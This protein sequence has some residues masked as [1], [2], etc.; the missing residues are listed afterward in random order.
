MNLFTHMAEWLNRR[1]IYVF[2][3]LVIFFGWYYFVG[4]FMASDAIP[5]GVEYPR[6]MHSF[7]V[8]E[9][10]ARCGTCMLWS[11]NMG[12]YPAF[13]DIYGAF[14]HPVAVIMSLLFGAIQGSKLTVIL[15]FLMIAL[16]TWWLSLILSMH[17]IARIWAAM[18]SMFGGHIAARLEVGSVGLPLSIAAG[19][20]AIVSVYYFIENPSR[21]RAILT[22][23]MLGMFILAGQGYYQLGFVLSVPLF[24]LLAYRMDMFEKPRQELTRYLTQMTVV[25]VGIAAPLLYTFV[26]YGSY[27]DK[28]RDDT[29]SASMSIFKLMENWFNTN[30]DIVY[31]TDFNALPFPYLYSTYIGYA[32]VILAVLGIIYI[33]EKHLRLLYDFFSLFALVQF[34]TA[35]GDF[36]KW[37]MSFGNDQVNSVITAL[38]YVV[39]LN[40]F[41]TLAI[42]I[43]AM[44]CL[45]SLLTARVMVQFGFQYKNLENYIQLKIRLAVR[46]EK[47]LRYA[48]NGVIAAIMVWN[49]NSMILMNSFWIRGQSPY[50]DN[51][52]KFLVAFNE[53]PKDHLIDVGGDWIV[54]QLMHAGYKIINPHLSWW[55]GSSE[56]LNY[57][58]SLS[59]GVPENFEIMQTFDDVWF[60]SVNNDPNANYAVLEKDNGELQQCASQAHGGSVTVD[61]TSDQPGKLRIFERAIPGWYVWL[62]GTRVTQGNSQ[63]MT[64]YIPAGTHQIV[65]RYFPWSTIIGII[66]AL[67]TWLV[68]LIILWLDTRPRRD[69]PL[70]SNTVPT[71]AQRLF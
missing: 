29:L 53:V 27:F 24:L 42:I 43:M 55:F 34:M 3:F 17:P 39:V 10:F 63:W 12:G 19:W 62:D 9:S 47:W 8:W 15:A 68:V 57:K 14:M 2:E 59:E 69:Q 65:Y 36:L 25:A 31:T 20:L 51:V 48:I 30:T 60:L 49:L 22:G 37:I 44:L 45:H 70:P 41:G 7:F 66:Q 64:V 40:G 56:G 6:N 4:Y 61:C 23:I 38:R 54:M 16:A 50:D 21:F 13:A 11:N 67:I 32:T 26:A 1:K 46:Q 33:R 71:P 35:S 5:W 52:Q 18:A 58:Y 28:D